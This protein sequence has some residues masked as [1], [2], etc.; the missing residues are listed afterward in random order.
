MHSNSCIY[1]N[2]SL[3][4][5]EKFTY[6]RSYLVDSAKAGVAG[7]ALTE[8]NSQVSYSRSAWDELFLLHQCEAKAGEFFLVRVLRLIKLIVFSYIL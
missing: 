8:A 5:V 2:K 3:T 7:F 4:P 1:E 6:L